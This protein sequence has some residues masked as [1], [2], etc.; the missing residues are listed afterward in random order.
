MASARR[1]GVRSAPAQA[2]HPAELL[3][4]VQRHL[5]V[6]GRQLRRRLRVPVQLRV[7]ATLVVERAGRAGPPRRSATTVAARSGGAMLRR[8]AAAARPRDGARRVSVKR[9]AVD[10]AARGPRAASSCPSPTTAKKSASPSTPTTLSDFLKVLSA[11]QTFT[12]ELRNA[13][14]AALCMT[15]DGY[16]CVIMPLARDA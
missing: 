1:A 15:A 9:R 8:A 10:M 12:I 16:A 13:E 11:E 6:V 2:L 14:S 7:E 5:A 3:R 4:L